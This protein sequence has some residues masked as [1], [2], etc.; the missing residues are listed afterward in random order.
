MWCVF[1]VCTQTRPLAKAIS[2][3]A[4]IMKLRDR[5]RVSFDCSGNVVKLDYLH[6]K[7]HNLYI[8]IERRQLLRVHFIGPNLDKLIWGSLELV[9]SERIVRESNALHSLQ[10]LTN[11]KPI[12]QDSKWLSQVIFT[13]TC[14]CPLLLIWLLS[15]GGFSLFPF[16]LR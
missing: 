1:G 2:N 12:N 4:I 14:N 13:L 11:T 10:S 8:Y 7:C 9:R 5:H 15:F 3:T 6:F 16:P